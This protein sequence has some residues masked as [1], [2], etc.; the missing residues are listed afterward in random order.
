LTL[1]ED[2]PLRVI[3]FAVGCRGLGRLA[4]TAREKALEFQD[5][6][7]SSIDISSPLGLYGLHGLCPPI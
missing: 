7:D 5:R 1:V 2:F 3:Q 4:Q 6:L